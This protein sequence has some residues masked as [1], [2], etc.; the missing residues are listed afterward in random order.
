MLLTLQGNRPPA[1]LALSDGTVFMGQ[2]IGHDGHT[3]GEVVFNTSMTGYQEILTDPSYCQQL[4]TLTYSHIGN[5][6][7]NSED[8][9]ADRI[10][11]AGLI[12]KNLPLMHSNFRA[13]SDLTHFLK[14]QG[15]VA[16]ADIDTRMLTRHLRERGAQNGAIVAYPAKH[17]I[18]SEDMAQAVAL[19]QQ[20]P[21]MN[22]LDLASKVSVTQAY[23]WRE[24]EWQLGAGYRKL[25]KA[26]YRLVAYD[27]G[28]KRNILRMLAERGC[29]VTVVP[30]TTTAEQVLQ[31]KPDGV[32]LSNGPGDP[33][34]CTYAIEATQ[35]LLA[36]KIPLFGI[37][38]GHQI[39][40]LACG[41]T[42][43]KMKFGHHG[44]NHPVKDLQ[45]SRVSITSQN[46][47]FAVDEKSLPAH[48]RATHVSLFDGSLQGLELTDQPAF[49]FQGH[50]EASPG[51]H[52][53]GYLFD[54]FIHSM[55]VSQHG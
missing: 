11:A 52:D 5:Y 44:A 13:D 26:S 45:S 36:H 29:D 40:A 34:P 41:A 3:V 43:Y 27:F 35:A 10:H 1:I 49:S 18:T 55:A 7:V 24:T 31:L 32:F 28:V 42:T 14:A 51:P 37:C 4:V 12:I 22:G 21:A 2:S 33:G 9:E 46:H 23:P 19:A 39:L 25:E 17:V 48:V 38:L 54:R 53:I 30:A 20:A 15:T 47:G 8:N 16:I 50:P 6:G